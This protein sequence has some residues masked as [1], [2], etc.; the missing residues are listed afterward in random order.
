MH[1]LKINKNKFYMKM[2]YFLIIAFNQKKKYLTFNI[3]MVIQFLFN[4]LL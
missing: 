3:L 2:M 4:Y 1:L